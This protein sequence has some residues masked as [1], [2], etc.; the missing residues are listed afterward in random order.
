[1]ADDNDNCKLQDDWQPFLTYVVEFQKKTKTKDTPI[2]SLEYRT[3]AHSLEEGVTE[4]WSGIE[5]QGL[6]DW[7]LREV[8]ARIQADVD[9]KKQ[10]HQSKLVEFPARFI[11]TGIL[12]EDAHGHRA[13]CK[14]DG[15]FT[16]YVDHDTQITIKAYLSATT[17]IPD[18]Y[19]KNSRTDFLLTHLANGERKLL[20]S[21]APKAGTEKI[22]IATLKGIRLENGVYTIRAVTIINNS[23]P[24]LDYLESSLLI[25]A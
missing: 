19:I 23:I 25:V 22:L 13:S 5:G 15:F 10:G 6:L 3:S 8:S 16:G 20:G 4:I 1:M 17:H 18:D 7:M 12:V 14:R 9:K 24:L 21:V 2:E 11:T